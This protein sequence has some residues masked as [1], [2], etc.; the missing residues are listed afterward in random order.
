MDVSELFAAIDR[1]DAQ[2]FGQFIAEEGTF[3]M[4]S[5]PATVGPE[6]TTEFV[7]GFFGTLSWVRH[8]NLVT[9]GSGENLFIEGDVTYGLPNGTEV[10]VPFL[11]RLRVEGDK[12]AEYRI[13]LDPTPV[14]AAFAQ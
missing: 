7:R 14:A 1:R 13:Y 9:Y 10:T 11:N 6:A 2:A 12:A 5:L 3:R 8:E 4:G